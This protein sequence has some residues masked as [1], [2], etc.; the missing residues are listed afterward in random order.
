MGGGCEEKVGSGYSEPDCIKRIGEL[1]SAFRERIAMQNE[2]NR[3]LEQGLA[4]NKKVLEVIGTISNVQAAMQE[5]INFIKEGVSDIKNT[6]ALKADKCDVAEI[7]QTM[8]QKADKDDVDKLERLDQLK[9]NGKDLDAVVLD[10]GEVKADVKG[11]KDAPTNDM[12]AIKVGGS[13]VVIGAI[14][15]FIIAIINSR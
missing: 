2:K 3:Q 13:I 6:I 8:A 15:E 12:R 14:V 10:I 4:D 5:N 11:I 1:E 9:V 7:K